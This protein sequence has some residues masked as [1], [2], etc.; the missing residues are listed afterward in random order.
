[1]P[2]I[3]IDDFA[4]LELKVGTVLEA[5]VLQDSEKLLKLKVDLGE[6]TPRQILAGLK[7][8]FKPE[9]FIGKQVVVAANLEP[10]MMMGLESQGMILAADPSTGSGQ[11]KPV[12]LKPAGKVAPGTKIR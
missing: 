4:K 6:S 7:P 11:A 9:Y 3:N 8:Y 10:R 5:E 12:L 2:T 1:M